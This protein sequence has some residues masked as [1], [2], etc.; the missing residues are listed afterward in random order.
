MTCTGLVIAALTF[1]AAPPI[2]AR[3]DLARVD[4]LVQA[5]MARQKIPGVAVAV[6]RKGAPVKAQGYGKA[7]V[8]HDVAVTTETIFQ[9]GS[10]GKQFTAAAVMLLVEDGRLSLADPLPKFFADAPPNWQRI[11]VR[12]LLTHTSGLPDYT[13][14]TIDYRRDYSE[15]ELLRFAYGL[16]LEFEPGA[17]WNYS[18]TGYVVLG[19]VIRK[20]S[21]MFYGDVLRTRVF[22]PLGM[23]TARIITEEDIVPHRS[24]GYRLVRGELKNQNWVAPKLN[25]TADGSLYLSLQDLIAWD[26]GIRAQRVLRSDSWARIFTPVTLNSGNTYPYGFGWSVDDFAGR[27]AQR[28]GGSWQGFQTHIARFPD[29]DLTII[30]LTNLAQANPE[31]IRDGIAAI[32]EP[33]LTRPELKPITDTDPALQTRVLRLIA[34]TAAGRLSPAEFAYVRAGFFPDTAQSYADTLRDAG[35]VTKLTLLEKRKLGDDETYTY[36]VAFARKTLR[37]T[38][39]IAPDGRIASFSVRPVSS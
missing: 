27:P 28:H 3:L 37:L 14:G 17:R 30:V 9:S 13:D 15:E 32:V 24:A 29:A 2:T 31:R 6:I 26:A 35:A 39:A 22:D 11:T 19:I 12:H 21:G 7:N 25:T 16:T 8:E 5:E 23:R 38:I 4:S 36:D 34:D 18:N 1:V 10:V 20:A 33:A